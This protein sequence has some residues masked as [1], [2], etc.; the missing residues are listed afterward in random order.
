MSIAEIMGD[1]PGQWA[2]ITVLLAF[3][4]AFATGLVF[5]YLLP[6]RK[7]GCGH[8]HGWGAAGE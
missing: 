3:S 5:G 6:C 7:V 8:G 4:C 1:I 2:P